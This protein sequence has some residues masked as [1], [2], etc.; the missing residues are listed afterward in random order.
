LFFGGE[1]VGQFDGKTALV[2]GGGAGIGRETALAFARAGARVVVGNRNVARGNE[3]I[4]L[5]RRAGGTAV[6]CRTDVTVAGDVEA[7]VQC[8]VERFGTLDYAFNNAGLFAGLCPIT[9]QSEADYDRVVDTNVKGVW[10][11]LKYELRQ[12]LK[13]GSGVIV[14]NASVG[15]VIGSGAGLAPYTA[16]KHAVIGLT[17]CAALENARSGVRINAV[18]PA[19]IDT[20]MADQFAADLGLTMAQFGDVHPIGRVGQPRE[21]AGAVLWICSDEA[22]FMTG[23][24]LVIDG[25]LT[26]Q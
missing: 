24:S 5:I 16:S 12:M 1:H 6:F 11:A 25:G 3:T 4:E 9:E 19:V 22:S 26:A 8:A 14:N 23:S 13:Q 21:V 2:T 20:D 18:C 7:L 17:K 15:G 10:L